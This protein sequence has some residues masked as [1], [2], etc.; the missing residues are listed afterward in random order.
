MTRRLLNLLAIVLLAA[1]CALLVWGFL[2]DKVHTAGWPR[3]AKVGIVDLT[4]GTVRVRISPG[5]QISAPPWALVLLLAVT[6]PLVHDLKNK[7]RGR[8]GGLCP[9][10]GYDMRATPGRCPECG[11]A[12]A[13]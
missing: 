12:V 5:N 9:A 10:C 8:A 13:T 11:R 7:R 1:G 4:P 2:Y 3:V 6:P